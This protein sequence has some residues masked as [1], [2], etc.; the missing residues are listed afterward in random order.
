M[1]AGITP[2]TSSAAT[3]GMPASR[4]NSAG[5]DAHETGLGQRKLADLQHQI[6]ADG[7]NSLNADQD[8]QM[9]IEDLTDE[10]RN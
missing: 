5:A 4:V 6:D 10:Q 9:R 8:H 1:R 3:K 2:A 7:E